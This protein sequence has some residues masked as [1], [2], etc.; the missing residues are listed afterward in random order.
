MLKAYV[1][2][3]S[4]LGAFKDYMKALQ[5]D[6]SGA[7]MIEYALLVGLMA[8]AVVGAGAALTPALNTKIGMITAKLTAP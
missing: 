5:D 4:Q 2:A 7:A 3:Q 6:D 8:V 1:F